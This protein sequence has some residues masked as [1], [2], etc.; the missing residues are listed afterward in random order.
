MNVSSKL[1]HIKKKGQKVWIQTEAT[2]F[3][4]RLMDLRQAVCK[5]NFYLILY[6]SSY[7]LA[8]LHKILFRVIFP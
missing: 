3:T 6:V 7:F 2:H 1:Y 5:F 4:C 8:Y